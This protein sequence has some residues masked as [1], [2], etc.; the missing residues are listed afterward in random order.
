MKRNIEVG[1]IVL[2]VD[3][4]P[5]C[6]WALGRVLLVHRGKG[7]LVRSVTVKTGSSVLQR[8]I[9]KLCLILEAEA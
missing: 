3:G 6:S 2:V 9:H 7:N 4:N 5:R 8:P 1:D